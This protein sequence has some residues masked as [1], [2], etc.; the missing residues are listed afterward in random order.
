VKKQPESDGNDVY[1]EIGIVK[2]TKLDE[3]YEIPLN[4]Q[5]CK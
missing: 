1:E 3:A 2:I 4:D 5:T